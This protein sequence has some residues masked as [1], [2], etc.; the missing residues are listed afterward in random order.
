VQTDYLLG[1]SD[2]KTS[3]SNETIALSRADNPD[4]DLPEAALLEIENFKAYVRQ[5]YKR[6]D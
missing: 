4:D 3:L 5:K 1:I 6:T 2:V